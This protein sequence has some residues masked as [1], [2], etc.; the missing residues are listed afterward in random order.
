MSIVKAV[1]VAAGSGKR[2]PGLRPKQFLPLAGAP[3]L[4]CSLSSV[5]QAASVSSVVLVVPEGEIEEARRI[6]AGRFAKLAQV[7]CGGAVRQESVRIGALAAGECDVVVVHDA[8][9]PFAPAW[10]FDAVA[11]EAD[12]GGAAI[13]VAPISDTVKQVDDAGAVAATL[14]RSRLVLAQTPQ[15]FRRELLLEVLDRAKGEGIL[16]TDE[17]ALFERF[18]RPVRAVPGSRL[19]FKVTDPEDLALA[20]ALAGEGPAEMR[21]GNGEDIHPLRPGRPL[22]LGGV[23]IPFEKGLSGHSDGDVLAHAVIDALCGAA[24]LPNIG[25]LFPDSDPRWK[26]ASSLDMIR[27]VASRL[28]E[29]GWQAVNVDSVVLCDAPRLGGHQAAMRQ[30]MAEALGVDPGRIGIKGKSAEGLGAEGRG[31]GISARAVALLRR[32]PTR[33]EGSKAEEAREEQATRGRR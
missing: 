26:G 13:A 9:R 11:A 22:V 24:S 17:A 12:A 1:I 25:E 6:A 23:A 10:L 19:N 8:A 14:D 29:A 30:A 27:Q 3:M 21:I 20:R 31:E 33:A 7:V 18:G 16:A 2:L 15:A 5:Q 4:A 32:V 28:R